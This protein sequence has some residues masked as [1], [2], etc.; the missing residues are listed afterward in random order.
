MALGK[1]IEPD[2]TIAGHKSRNQDKSWSQ[3]AVLF[4]HKKRLGLS[5]FNF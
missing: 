5:S 2:M 3:I 4:G 1:Y